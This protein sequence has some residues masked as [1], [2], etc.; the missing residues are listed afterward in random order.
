MLFRLARL[1]HNEALYVSQV[2]AKPEYSSLVNGTEEYS[3]DM[4][5]VTVWNFTVYTITFCFLHFTDNL[6]LHFYSFADMILQ[7]QLIIFYTSEKLPTYCCFSFIH[8]IF[9]QIIIYTQDLFIC[10]I[11][12]FYIMKALNVYQYY[13]GH[14]TLLI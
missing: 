6:I 9:L 4:G 3:D 8:I 2:Q 10:F 5:G 13:I 11:L 14:I 12:Y 1:T 7:W